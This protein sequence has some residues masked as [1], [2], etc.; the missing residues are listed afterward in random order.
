[1]E[2]VLMAGGIGLVVGFS[3]GVLVMALFAA[4]EQDEV[5]ESRPVETHAMSAWWR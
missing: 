3:L 2:Y 1:M 4:S 5:P